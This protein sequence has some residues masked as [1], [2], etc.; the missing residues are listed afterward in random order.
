MAI[1]IKIHP[2]KE[3][4]ESIFTYSDG[5]LLWK[6]D[7]GPR[8]KAGT[9]AGSVN[10]GVRSGYRRISINKSLYQ[11]HRLVWI[12]FNGD[13]PEEYQI[14]HINQDRTDNRIEN[15]RLVSHRTNIAH[16]TRGV[17]SGT[18][19]VHWVGSKERWCVRFHVDGKDKYFGYYA[20]L[21][22]AVERAEQVRN[23]L[24]C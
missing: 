9:R 8:F 13:I 7:R 11:E 20:D 5:K 6:E 10:T 12:L 21:D 2:S 4:L 17:I 15:L 22:Q 23:T 16:H 3:T 18:P 1:K 19:N 24:N 14:D